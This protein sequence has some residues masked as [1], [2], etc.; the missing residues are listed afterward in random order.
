MKTPKTRAEWA[1][2]LEEP[3]MTGPQFRAMRR[4]KRYTQQEIAHIIAV[5]SVVSISRWE[6]DIHKVPALAARVLI[7]LPVNPRAAA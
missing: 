6:R 5:K 1:R 7:D 4:K 2:A 3:R